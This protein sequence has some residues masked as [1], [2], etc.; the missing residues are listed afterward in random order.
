[1]KFGHGH[2]SSLLKEQEQ[3]LMEGTTEIHTLLELYETTSDPNKQLEIEII[4]E[5]KFEL[6]SKEFG[7]YYKILNNDDESSMLLVPSV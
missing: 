1:M 7:A 2:A 5:R 4:M 6:L 3:T